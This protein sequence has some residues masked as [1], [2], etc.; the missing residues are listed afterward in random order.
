MRTAVH[1]T[2]R[3]GK[4]ASPLSSLPASMP[5]RMGPFSTVNSSVFPFSV[6]WRFRLP[7]EPLSVSAFAASV[8]RTT[9]GL[10]GS[11]VVSIHSPVTSLCAT[12]GMSARSTRIAVQVIFLMT[13]MIPERWSAVLRAV[14][15][16]VCA[17]SNEEARAMKLAALLLA[18][19]PLAVHHSRRPSI[20]KQALLYSRSPRRDREH[21]PRHRN[22]GRGP[23]RQGRMAFPAASGRRRRSGRASE[24]R[25]ERIQS[26]AISRRQG[27]R[28]LQPGR[29]R[30]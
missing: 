3:L 5:F 1:L 27:G 11:W 6:P 9:C 15:A 4:T 8:R 16:S 24:C 23:R 13:G 20:W 10:N 17:F 21:R 7:N 22:D 14:R 26:P 12:R 19:L 2:V 30:S 29:R 25:R 18:G 28:S